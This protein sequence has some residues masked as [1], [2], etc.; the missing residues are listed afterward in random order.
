MN[1]IPTLERT[2]TDTQCRECRHMRPDDGG[3]SW[4]YSPQIMKAQNGRGTRCI[5]ER[6]SYEP[7]MKARADAAITKCGPSAANFERKA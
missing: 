4:C 7:D 2:T 1:P 5:F 6:D 3:A